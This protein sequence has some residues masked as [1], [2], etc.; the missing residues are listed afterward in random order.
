MDGD[1]ELRWVR[2]PDGTHLSDSRESAGA[3][4][5]LLREDGTNKL[6][7][8]TE[9]IRADVNSLYDQRS[10]DYLESGDSTPTFAD[11]VIGA[12]VEAVVVTLLEAIDW[13]SVVD[14]TSGVLKRTKARITRGIRPNRT[15]PDTRP[16]TEVA[17]AEMLN[18]GAEIEAAVT[19]LP[20]YRMSSEE[21]R[22]R[23]MAALV[24]E[25]FAAHQRKLLAS[26]II[27]DDQTPPELLS[28]VKLVLE[29]RTSSLGEDDLAA[30]MEYL[31]GAQSANE[32]LLLREPQ[33]AIGLPQRRDLPNA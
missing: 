31:R 9:S 16:G 13:D 4:R 2:V 22:N 12:M 5:D 7:G 3:S 6:L 17:V 11:Q 18:P 25:A 10:D 24:A 32:A 15:Q 21:Y 26:T 33:R 8:P 1:W 28:S 14:K 23:A 20:P 29:G 30:V 27:D 19:E